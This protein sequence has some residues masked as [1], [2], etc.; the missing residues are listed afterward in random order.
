[1]IKLTDDQ[2]KTLYDICWKVQEKWADKTDSAENLALYERELKGRLQDAG[3]IVRVEA[4]TIPVGVVVEGF[5][6]PKEFDIEKAA[7]D[8]RKSIERGEEDDMRELISGIR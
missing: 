2:V 6:D 3:F 7:Y 5:T 4:I 1:M 8:V